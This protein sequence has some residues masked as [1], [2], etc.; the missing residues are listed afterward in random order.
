MR[1]IVFGVIGMIWGVAILGFKLL[2]G[3]GAEGGSAFQA[4]TVVAL[5]FAALL[6]VVGAY[7]LRKGVQERA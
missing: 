6:I 2:G 4:G 1:N 5:V 7:F 3:S